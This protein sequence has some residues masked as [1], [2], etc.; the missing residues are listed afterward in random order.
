MAELTSNLIQYTYLI[1]GNLKFPK[2]NGKKYI[3]F[4]LKQEIREY[5]KKD[6]NL[7]NF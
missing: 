6:I 2:K 5:I 3:F 1:I 7:K 4:N